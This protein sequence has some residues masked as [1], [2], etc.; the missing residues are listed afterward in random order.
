MFS[1]S[2]SRL[3]AAFNRLAWSNLCA[4]SAEQI[5]LAAAPMVAVLA[6]GAGEGQTGLLQMAQ[7]LPF[8]LLS[9]PA[10]V[11]ADRTSRR[12]LMASAEALRVL[13][14]LAILV[15]IGAS[16]LTLPLLAMLGF[17]G[18][19]G[20]VAYGVAAPSLV[21]ALVARDSLAAA[22]A[23]LEVART[24]AFIAG[25][26][27]AGLVV[28][29]LG[30]APAFAFAAALST[31]AVL[32]FLGLEEPPRPKLPSRHF[33]HDLAEG[34]SFVLRHELL[35]PTV[36]AAVIFNTSFFMIQAVFVPYAVRSLGMSATAIGAT[37]ACNGIGLVGGALLAPYISRRITFGGFVTLG[38]VFGFLSSAVMAATLW[39]PS[40]WLPGVAYFLMGI[41]PMLWIIGTATL[42][43]SVTPP[44]ML[45]RVSAI[46]ITATQGSR[47]LGAALGALIGGT[48]GAAP[49]L[50]IA[51]AGFFA[52]MVLVL[53]SPL[54]RL[55]RQPEPARQ[56][57]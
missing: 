54:P 16:W 50:V 45:G 41:G 2:A 28:G 7:T 34:A 38:P 47:P 23:R 27:A 49:C 25:P 30:A 21:P 53:L 40:I 46:V 22:N 17:I 42:R 24:T 8:L 35:R 10:G 36:A 33:F 37:F 39:L 3:P 1:R 20:T 44:A 57:G 19:S 13:S 18:A 29:W 4:Q 43:Q 56:I 12:R 48:W 6:L 14:L 51:A 26:A 52:Q 32:M 31:L 11:L 55:A 9:F 5:G 15:L